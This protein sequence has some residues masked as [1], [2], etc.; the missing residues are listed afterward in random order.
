M[1]GRS[2]KQCGV[3]FREGL[4]PSAVPVVSGDGGQ[5]V[6]RD[7]SMRVRAS[8][9]TPWGSVP[10]VKSVSKPPRGLVK[11][12]LSLPQSLVA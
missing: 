10:A 9:L 5:V 7:L 1:K 4:V 8:W 6:L 12:T 2:R 3:R 11:T